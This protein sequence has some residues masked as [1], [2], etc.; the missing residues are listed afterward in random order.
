MKILKP[1]EIPFHHLTTKC[2][3]NI[4][5]ETYRINFTETNTPLNFVIIK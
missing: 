2:H 4:E 3:A 5:K 1:I